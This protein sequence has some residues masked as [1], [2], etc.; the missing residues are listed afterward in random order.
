M[1]NTEREVAA[2]YEQAD[3]SCQRPRESAATPDADD[4]SE[5]RVE[6]VPPPVPGCVCE[7]TDY[8]AAGPCRIPGHDSRAPAASTDASGAESS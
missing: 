7:A 4:A 3:E 8:E 5:V 6:M 2:A 1:T